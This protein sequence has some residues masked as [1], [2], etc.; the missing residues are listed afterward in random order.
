MKALIQIH[1]LAALKV[2]EGT[3]SEVAGLLVIF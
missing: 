1:Y 2:S 3:D